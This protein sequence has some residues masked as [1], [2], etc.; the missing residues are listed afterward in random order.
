VAARILGD[1]LPADNFRTLSLDVIESIRVLLVSGEARQAD[2]WFTNELGVIDLVLTGGGDRTYAPATF[3]V[4]HLDEAAAYDLQDLD[5]YQVIVL[6]N[7]QSL[8]PGMVERLDGWVRAGGGLLL[9]LGD[10]CIS[11]GGREFYNR[12]LSIAGASLLPAPLGE[13]VELAEQD[14]A[15]L[16]L[17]VPEHPIF[18]Q[19][20]D[21]PSVFQAWVEQYVIVRP[22]STDETVRTLITYTGI[23]EHPFLV[24]KVHGRGRVLLVTT[25]ADE[26]WNRLMAS[27][28]LPIFAV[29]SVRYLAARPR[30]GTNRLVGEP[31]QGSYPPEFA[32]A[33][34]LT[35]PQPVLPGD[36]EGRTAL[37]VHLDVPEGKRRAHL[38]YDGTGYP[39]FYLLTAQPRPG[40][41]GPAL[42]DAFAVNLNP[43]EGDLT[44]ITDEEL[45]H[46]APGIQLAS[47]VEGEEVEPVAG[48][49]GEYPGWRLALWMLLVVLVLETFLA[50]R[51]GDYGG[52]AGGRS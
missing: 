48:S 2:T 6:G 45:Q 32:G 9:F 30:S 38:D 43:A 3:E 12:T 11:S 39:G 4:T 35:I 19:L 18:R 23:G 1:N 34:V 10:H 44:R 51:F 46:L 22:P 25:T 8:S 15:Q 50:R 33:A 31:L 52:L 27:S 20:A 36:L 26:E 47:A 13:H 16:I 7:V 21:S 5:P 29:E 40:A 41:V 42:W 14:L 24:E 49:A 37:P 17:K 28:F